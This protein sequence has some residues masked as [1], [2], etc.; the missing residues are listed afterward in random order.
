LWAQLGRAELKAPQC[1]LLMNRIRT[2][3]KLHSAA[4]ISQV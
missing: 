1:Q 2:L 4:E 3:P